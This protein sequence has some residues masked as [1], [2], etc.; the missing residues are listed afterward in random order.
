MTVPLEALRW[1]EIKGPRCGC[2]LT[3]KIFRITGL[4]K[5]LEIYPSLESIEGLAH[6]A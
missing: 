2:E 3:L 5:A 1:G 6:S 4:D